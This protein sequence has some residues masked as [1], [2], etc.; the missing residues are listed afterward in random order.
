MSTGK[1]RTF[2]QEITEIE[3]WQ[4]IIALQAP[5]GLGK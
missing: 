4:K 5:R 2:W 3:K 1:Q